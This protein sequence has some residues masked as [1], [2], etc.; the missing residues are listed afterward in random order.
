M[1]C[2]LQPQSQKNI[3]ISMPMTPTYWSQ[4]TDCQLGEE[5]GHIEN[6]ALKNKMIINKA[7]TKELVFSRPHPTKFELILKCLTHLMAVADT[8]GGRGLC[9]P[10]RSP[11][12][13]MPNCRG[14]GSLVM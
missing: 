12:S 13:D 5:F 10:P 2:D 4:N 3:L 9:P 8:E 7:R 6:W 1:K 11:G 14:I